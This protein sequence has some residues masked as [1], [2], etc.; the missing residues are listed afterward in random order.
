MTALNLGQGLQKRTDALLRRLLTLG[1]YEKRAILATS[2]FVLLGLAL[3][4]AM[5]VRLGEPYVPPS[6][7]LFLILCAAPAIGVATFFQLGL[8]R[9]VTRYI[10]GQGAVLVPVAVCLSALIWVLLLVLSGVQSVVVESVDARNVLVVPRSVVMLYPILGSAFVWGTRQIAG[11][12]LKGIGVELPVRSPGKVKKVVIY[13]AGATGVQ[14]LEDLRR[15]GAYDTIGFIDASPTLWGQYIAG[16]KVYRP[17]RLP[18]I[19]QRKEVREVLLAMPRA[20]RM[21]RRAALRELEK[22]AVNVRTLPAIEDLAAGRVTVSDLRPVEVEDLLGRDPVPP[23]AA[24]LARNIAGKSVMVTGAGGSIGSELVRQVLRQGPRRLVL[25]DA[26]EGALFEVEHEARELVAA[27]NMA[28]DAPPRTPPTV[29]AVLG[30]IQNSAL[31]RRTIEGHRVETIYH[32]A[33]YKHVPMVE[34]NA[35]AGLHNNAFGTAVL[36]DAAEALGVER[37][38]LV[39][40]DK[41]VRPTSIM[42][43]SKR[44]AEMMLQARALNG[45][46]RRTVFTMVRFGNVLDSSGSVVRMFRRQIEAGGPVTVTDREAIRY[47]MSIPEAAALVIQAGAMATGG[48]VFVLDMGEPVKIDDLARSMIRLMGLEVRGEQH[49]DGDIAI[50]YIGLRDGEKLHEELLLGDN[51]TPTEHPR[52]LKSH[53]PCMPQ[54]ELAKVMDALRAAMDADNLQAIHAALKR[55]VE[56]YRSEERR[57]PGIN[58]ASGE[59]SGRPSNRQS[60]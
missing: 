21:E 18:A 35:V 16:L 32:A 14:L 49:P 53:E 40:T 24:L 25:L 30:S 20:R 36:A 17:E 22:L 37:F 45:H 38:V 43:A 8:Y 12:L 60:P 28:S 2:D 13:G 39:S 7:K 47:F 50:R 31:L 59:I 48:D 9:L 11:L 10:S 33:A 5:S 52:I 26:S 27:G 46:G 29:V 41:A 58:G 54:G 57:P 51:V 1:R 23:N 3:W 19:V 56:G 44:L 15:S 42:G 6:P 55:A 34:H 4:L